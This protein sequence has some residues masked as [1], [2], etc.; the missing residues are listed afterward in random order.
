M[1]P[2]QT[3]LQMLADK[4]RVT[5]F[6][7][8]ILE[9][10]REGDVVADIGTGTGILAFFAVQAGARRVY[11]LEWGP[12]LD[13]AR[14]TALD[15]GYGD[16]IRFVAGHSMEVDL[17][18][19]VDVLVTETVGCFAFDEGITAIVDNAR[20]R[21]LKKGGRILPKRLVLKALPVSFIQRHPF[22]FL[23]HNFFDLEMGHLRNLA[24]N[25]VFS[26]QW[27]ELA[28][29]RLLAHCEALVEIDLHHGG[30]V[31]YPLHMSTRFNVSTEGL[32]HG[33]VV[34][35]EVVLTQKHC[36]RLL[37]GQTF[38]PTHWEFTFFPNHTPLQ[39]GGGD[40]LD[41]E[42]TLTADNGFVWQ[43]VHHRNAK[44]R[45]FSHL[46]LFGHPSLSHLIRQPTQSQA[47]NKIK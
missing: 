20:R 18:E 28:Q 35:P 12:I 37:E 1:F 4:T 30:L 41:F 22:E 10:V 45:I 3:H 43:I 13:V 16:R 17:P 36:I 42:L 39:V 38:V 40:R 24:A 5:A 47:K 2:L 9:T 46:S 23:H 31:T 14:Q 19:R 7:R 6:G 26:L 11:A 32:F 33:V 15:N 27:L 21:F 8:A 29:V 34:F 44:T 25:T